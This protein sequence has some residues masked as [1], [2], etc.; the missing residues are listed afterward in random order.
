MFPS[1]L[2]RTD[3]CVAGGAALPGGLDLVAGEFEA[4]GIR[5]PC[6]DVAT[7]LRHGGVVEQPTNRLGN[8]RPAKASCRQAAP[9]AEPF[10]PGRVVALIEAHRH[11]DLRHARSERLRHRADATVVH[12]EPPTA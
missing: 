3:D 11:D 8:R 10:D 5:Q 4:V 12:K 6:G 9:H 7:S 1:K 2:I